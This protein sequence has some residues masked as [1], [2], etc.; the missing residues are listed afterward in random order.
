MDWEKLF[1]TVSDVGSQMRDKSIDM[2]KRA[3]RNATDSQLLRKLE[4][5]TMSD[6]GREI[7]EAEAKR[8][9]LI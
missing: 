9:R 6:E 7:F 4:D 3:A 8:R 2:A 1:N 5:S